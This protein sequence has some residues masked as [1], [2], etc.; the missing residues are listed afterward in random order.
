MEHCIKSLGGFTTLSNSCLYSRKLEWHKPSG[1]HHHD[2]AKPNHDIGTQDSF[3]LPFC[4]TPLS[5]TIAFVGLHSARELSN[6]SVYSSAL[7]IANAPERIPPPA[8]RMQCV[9]RS[10]SS[11]TIPAAEHR[12]PATPAATTTVAPTVPSTILPATT[13]TRVSIR[14]SGNTNVTNPP[15]CLLTM[16]AT[17]LYICVVALGKDRWLHIRIKRAG[18]FGIALIDRII[19][20][21]LVWVTLAEITCM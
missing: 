8:P 1:P 9:T 3:S 5:T 21:V 7:P 15:P 16:R 13:T 4:Y 6:T 18:A 10:G 17:N 14:R 20:G 2:E 19:I 11:P 12:V